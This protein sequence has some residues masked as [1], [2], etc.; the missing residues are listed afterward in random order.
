MLCRMSDAPGDFAARIIALEK[1]VDGLQRELAQL[2]KQ[3]ARAV[4]PTGPVPRASPA[5]QPAL[6]ASPGPSV[7][8]A[9]PVPPSMPRSRPGRLDLET[10]I[11]RYGMLALATLL[12][13]AAVGTF[14]G[15]AVAHGLLG[16]LPRVVL[17]LAA[18][19]AIGAWGVWLRPRERSFGDSLLGLSL[20]ITHVCAWAAGP[21]M[22]LV[23]PF[24][25][26][27]LSA[28]A[29]V[30][31]AGFAL[32]QSDEP[33]W[34]VGFG[35][36]AIAPFVTSSGHGTAPMLAA[37]AA[38]VLIAGGSALGSRAWPI[39]ARVFGLA[40]ALFVLALLALPGIQHSAELALALPF[41]VAALGVVPFAQGAAIRPRLR[42]LGLLAC[43]AA[44]QVASAGFVSRTAA[45]VWV[46]LAGL[47][48]LVLMELVDSEPAGTLL[49]GLGRTSPEVPDWIDG[50]VI[51]V[52]FLSAIRF[53]LGATDAA[54][55]A[56]ALAAAALVFFCSRREGPLKDAAALAAFVAAIAAA[57]I[58]T[59]SSLQLQAAATSAVSVLFVVLERAVPNR[60]WRWAPQLALVLAGLAAVGAVTARASYAY[61]P[62]G[63]AESAVAL[64]VALAFIAVAALQREGL[65]WAL[66]AIFIFCWV[67]QEL[68]W[69]VSPSASTVLLVSW[70]AVTGVACV[71][72]GR[73]RAFPRLRHVGLG[74]AVIA[75]LLALKAAWGLPSTGARIGAY[76]V[77]SGF[78]L[79]IA[80]WYRRPGSAPVA[81]PA[82]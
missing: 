45:A 34:C 20:A 31:L 2:R 12:A 5:P 53:A 37:Y 68:A 32:V 67:H 77:V 47:A 82:S 59:R 65:A 13:L 48:W 42:T 24:L 55:A 22:H 17:G 58:A 19:A 51:P 15:W 6:R 21:E 80:W 10:L 73:A 23:P 25:A 81:P 57:L 3:P 71:G 26:L 1:A 29:S 79:G 11:G 46:A 14:V 62:F 27:A 33:L 60:T 54:T 36:A 4:P 16:P 43:A 28:A 78:L 61:V 30:A 38:A 39:A 9:L 70:Y 18:A 76:L 41:A 50:A 66:A 52:A 63:T 40:A 72:L 74:L 8:E 56:F 7:I 75:A 44:H 69:A 49:D 35:G 64:A